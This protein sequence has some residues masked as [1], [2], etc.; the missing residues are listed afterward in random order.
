MV[1]TEPRYLE[2][3]VVIKVYPVKTYEES[4]KFDGNRTTNADIV[5]RTGINDISDE[6]M[7]RRW[8]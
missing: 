6:L 3:L 7:K 5:Q 4:I 1:S 2:T 8:K